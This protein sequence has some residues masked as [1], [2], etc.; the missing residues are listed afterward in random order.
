MNGIIYF[1]VLMTL[2]FAGM[3]QSKSM[4]VRTAYI[5]AGISGAIAMVLAIIRYKNQKDAGK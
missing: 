3:A 1:F 4:D 5:I 2:F